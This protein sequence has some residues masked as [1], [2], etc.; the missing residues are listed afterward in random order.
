MSFIHVG[1]SVFHEAWKFMR[2][3]KELSRGFAIHVKMLQSKFIVGNQS[4]STNKVNVSYVLTF[5][6]ENGNRFIKF[7]NSCQI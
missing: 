5:P 4:Y 2:T 1:W 3:W 6:L 7:Y